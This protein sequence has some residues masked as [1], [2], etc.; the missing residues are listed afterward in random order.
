MFR[1]LITDM[2]TKFPENKGQEIAAIFLD[3]K[4]EEKQ[5]YNYNELEDQCRLVAQNFLK[6][7]RGQEIV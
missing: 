5:T 7:T 4:G 3:S 6:F 2:V 1:E